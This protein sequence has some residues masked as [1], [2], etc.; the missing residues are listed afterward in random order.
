[1][2][3]QVFINVPSHFYFY[4]IYIYR[5]CVPHEFFGMKC[6]DMCHVVRYLTV[7][8]LFIIQFVNCVPCKMKRSI[9]C[10]SMTNILDQRI[11]G[12]P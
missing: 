1:M 2:N 7:Q 3:V 12:E 8:L 5:P 10:N 4:C 6:S 11:F 9:P